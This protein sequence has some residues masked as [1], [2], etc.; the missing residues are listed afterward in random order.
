[1][2][3]QSDLD[4]I[5]ISAKEK[6]SIDILKSSLLKGINHQE[7]QNNIVISNLRHFEALSK[8]EEAVD[9][10]LDGID[11]NIETDLLAMDMRDA[12]FFV[13]SITGSVSNDEILGNIFQNFCICK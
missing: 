6:R 10:V 3:Q 11:S 8:A 12:L 1:V 4:L 13:G 9:R 5:L 7:N 2:L